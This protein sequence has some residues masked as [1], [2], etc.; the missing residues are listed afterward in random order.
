MKE[1]KN[2]ERIINIKLGNI[3]NVVL[4][5]WFQHHQEQIIYVVTV[6]RMQKISKGELD[7]QKILQ[8]NH[9]EFIKQYKFKNSIKRNYKM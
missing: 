2:G 4:V 1:I 3:L 5:I 8:E 6:I 9:I 7:I